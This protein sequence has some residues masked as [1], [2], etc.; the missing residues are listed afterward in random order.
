VNATSKQCVAPAPVCDSSCGLCSGTSNSSCT[1]CSG[2]YSWLQQSSNASSGTCVA[3]ANI[4]TPFSAYG[5]LKSYT[6][7]CPTS[8]SVLNG[9]YC[10]AS[11]CLS[12]CASCGSSNNACW[13]CAGSN[14]VIVTAGIGPEGNTCA[15]GACPLGSALTS[16][17]LRCEP[18]NS[19]CG[20]CSAP[21]DSSS[22]LGCMSGQL[23]G[24]SPPSYC[25]SQCDPGQS[26]NSKWCIASAASIFD[27]DR[28]SDNT[29]WYPGAIVIGVVV[30]LAF[31]VFI[32]YIVFEWIKSAPAPSAEA[33]Q[34]QPPAPEPQPPQQENKEVS[35]QD[36][37]PVIDPAKLEN[38][39]PE[40]KRP[41]A[42]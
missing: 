33:N 9:F 6:D 3:V 22:C 34:P 31:F 21:Y 5:A 12:G 1:V 35:P 8:N 23:L 26:N 17:G 38:M 37:N 10:S 39:G 11:G 28:Y 4:S 25:V 13:K 7:T 16:D 27:G 32:G 41:E 20:N 30:L 40:I 42:T 15:A 2:P 24:N 29:K 14:F 36:V 18:C 19:A